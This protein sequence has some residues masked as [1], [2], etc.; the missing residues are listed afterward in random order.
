MRSTVK[1]EIIPR[2]SIKH[3]LRVKKQKEKKNNSKHKG[4]TAQRKGKSL[5]IFIKYIKEVKL[6]QI[7]VH[8]MFGVTQLLFG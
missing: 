3:L 2:A 4:P 5:Q 1:T 7:T 8:V 6:N